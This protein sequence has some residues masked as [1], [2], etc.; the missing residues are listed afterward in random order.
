MASRVEISDDWR[1]NVDAA[2][3][4]F[5]QNRLG[6]EIAKDAARYAPKRTGALAASVESHVEDGSL[7][8]S[9]TGGAGGR[10]YAV[11]LSSWA[12]AYSTRQPASQV[13]RSLRPDRSFG[14]RFIPSVPSDNR[15]PLRLLVA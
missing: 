13:R 4:N 15:T 10:T 11:F 12:T 5:L 1:E 7:I 8:V 14:R 3:E 9:A 2:V 6:P